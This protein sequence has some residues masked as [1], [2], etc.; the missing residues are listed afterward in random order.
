LSHLVLLLILQTTQVDGLQPI[1]IGSV[2]ATSNTRLLAKI[3]RGYAASCM[4]FLPYLAFLNL[5]PAQRPWT[6]A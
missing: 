2:T 3:G 1:V 5:P 4:P 6:M